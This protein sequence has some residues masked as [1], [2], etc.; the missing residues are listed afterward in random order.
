MSVKERRFR[1]QAEYA[2]SMFQSSLGDIE[3]SI[4]S[5]EY[6]LEI[7]PEYA[8]AIMTLGTVE[9]Q[10]Q[11]FDR[12][13]ELFHSLLSLPPSSA[14]GGESDLADI[15]EEA[16]DFLIQSGYYG[17]G[18]ELFRSAVDRF[19]DRS[20]YYLGVSCCAS[21]VEMFAESLAAAEKAYELDPENQACVNDL[22]RSL[23]DMDRLD[24]A[25]QYLSKAVDMDPTDE[26]ARDNL[27]LCKEAM[28]KRDR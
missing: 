2:N 27:R 1:A 16:G 25:F 24:E 21:H 12:G 9:Y 8:P 11:Q 23:F 17:D 6:A 3:A 14:D 13:K 5:L 15:I 10:R 22:G 18:L 20:T 26:M 19:P 7:D 4:Q 28:D